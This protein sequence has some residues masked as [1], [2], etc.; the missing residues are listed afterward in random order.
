MHE[1]ESRIII[2]S[3]GKST[4]SLLNG[5][6]YGPGVDE[7]MFRHHATNGCELSIG[8]NKLDRLPSRGEDE[9]WDHASKLLGYE[10]RPK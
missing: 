9:F 4:V 5:Q 7:I 2:I 6:Y 3:D 1:N 10:L 8:V